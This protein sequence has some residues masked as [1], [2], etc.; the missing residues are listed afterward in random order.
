MKK[1]ISIKLTRPEAEA[2]MDAGNAGI[3]DLHDAQDD[4]SLETAEV[5]DRALNKIGAAMAEAN[6]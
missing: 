5:A 2:L 6:W 3:A 4:E 1:V